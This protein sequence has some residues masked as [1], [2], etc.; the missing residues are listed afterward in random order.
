MFYMVFLYLLLA[1]ALEVFLNLLLTGTEQ[2]IH[3]FQDHLTANTVK[4]ILSG[5]K[6]FL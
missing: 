4:K 3:L 6:I 5:G 2:N 1:P